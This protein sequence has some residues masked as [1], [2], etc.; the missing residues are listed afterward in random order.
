MSLP[1][2][3]TQ[4]YNLI[5]LIYQ[6]TN[7]SN[8]PETFV[9]LSQEVNQ[10]HADICSALADPTRILILYLLGERPFTVGELALAL[11]ASQPT[12]SRHLKIL[13]ERGLAR[14]NRQAQS[15]EY[16]LYDPR[17]IEALDLLRAVL[18]DSLS[19]QASLIT[20]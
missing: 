11:N 10:L 3:I 12:T 16:S 5:I 18:R 20:E 9:K 17:I 15:V 13:R 14:A 2:R 8:N 6:Y 4:D 1:G 7:M 19:Q